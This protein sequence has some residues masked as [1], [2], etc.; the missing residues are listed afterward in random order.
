M[1]KIV[2]ILAIA[3][4]AASAFELH[5]RARLRAEEDRIWN[6]LGVSGWSE[7]E[8]S[9]VDLPEVQRLIAVQEALGENH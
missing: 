2:T 8:E 9:D 5:R 6:Q 3:L 1:K 4:L 7:I